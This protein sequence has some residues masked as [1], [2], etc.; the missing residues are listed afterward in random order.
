MIDTVTATSVTGKWVYVDKNITHTE[1]AAIVYLFA[2]KDGNYTFT[3]ANSITD[4][5][6]YIKDFTIRTIVP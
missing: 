1:A 4:D 2:M 6:F 5:L 3:G